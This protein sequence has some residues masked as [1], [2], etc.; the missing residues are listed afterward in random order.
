MASHATPSAGSPGEAKKS[1]NSFMW[2]IALWVT[3][4]LSVLGFLGYHFQFWGESNPTQA[5]N[6]RGYRSSSQDERLNVP[7]ICGKPSGETRPQA[8]IAPAKSS[9]DD[10]SHAPEL[11]MPRNCPAAD[12]HVLE[13]SG[14]EAQCY[15]HEAW[16]NW[17]AEGCEFADGF[18]IRSSTAEPFVFHY[19]IEG[20][21]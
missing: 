8:R 1:G 20:P 12:L 10:W 4:A 18:R 5:T 17:T 13:T 15:V 11:W 21:N 3:I 6:E 2:D 14:Y 19:W 16:I 9:P 7:T